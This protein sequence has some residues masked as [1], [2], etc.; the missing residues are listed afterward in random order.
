MQG[1][2]SD[3]DVR[4]LLQLIELN[5][6]TGE[7]FVE[8]GDSRFWSLFFHKGRL[9]YATSSSGAVERLKHCASRFSITDE[10]FSC[11]PRPAPAS[12]PEYGLLATMLDEK[13]IGLA[14]VQQI[15][16]LAAEE[17]LF[18][19]LGLSGGA[20]IFEN[21]DPLQP[22]LVSL[23]PGKLLAEA[24]R[25]LAEWQ[26]L[27][28]VVQSLEQRPLVLDHDQ[29][30]SQLPVAVYDQ[31]RQHMTGE[32][33]LRVLAR[34]LG[35]DAVTVARAIAP[36]L[37]Q[38]AMRLEGEIPSQTS[39]VTAAARTAR[40]A[41]VDDSI[42]IQKS[43]EFFL[44][45]R[46]YEVRTIANPLKALNEL[47]SFKPDLILLDIAMP[48]LDGYEVCGMLR[49]SNIFRSTPV[50]MLTGKDGHVDR[51]RAKMA[52]ATEYLTKPFGERELLDI[53]DK[54]LSPEA[55]LSIGPRS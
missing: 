34:L 33:S 25:R 12:A 37:Q 23:E 39:S 50:I 19:L 5:Q 11:T 31:L 26:K 52:G 32:C 17:I 53:V 10:H 13:R 6:R 44:Q 4:S 8:T 3:I 47:F 42:S 22:A 45:G 41:C 16:R 28:S 1:S 9:V 24:E 20:F 54:Y 51:V 35:R 49:K 36:Y 18:D 55:A 38:G 40:V 15:I 2:L 43:V 29:L 46:G 27:Q 21:S 48:R 30:K 14:Q 7:L